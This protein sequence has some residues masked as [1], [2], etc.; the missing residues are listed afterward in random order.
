MIILA[1]PDTM[2]AGEDFAYTM[3]ALKRATVI[4]EPTWGG[5][6]PARPYRLGD[7]FYAVIPDRRT[8]SP[9]THSNWEGIGVIPDIK[10]TPDKALALAREELQRRLHGSAPL[11]AAGK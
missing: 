8:I 5:A 10:S 3:Q 6:H 1:G 4:G 9:V 2:S 7:H 11:A